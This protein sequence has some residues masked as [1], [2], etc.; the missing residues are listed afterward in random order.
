MLPDGDTLAFEVGMDLLRAG[1]PLA[2]AL[3]WAEL[4]RAGV[5]TADLYCGLASALMQ[6][7]GQL[8][9]RPFELWAGKIF[10]EGSTLIAKA[11]HA[12]AMWKWLEE[13]PEAP[14]QAP[15]L[16]N[17]VTEMI[18]FLLVH[19]RVLPDAVAALPESE[20]VM[21]VR[22]LGER[23]D[24]MYVPVL[25]A[26]LEGGMGAEAA[27]S[28][29][30]G[31]INYVGWPE[32]QAS[33]M[34]ARDTPI[35]GVLGAELAGII[36]K[37]P[38]GWDGERTRACQPYRGIGRIDVE[39]RSAGPRPDDCAALIHARLGGALRDAVAWVRYAPCT[40]KKG[41]MRVD[42]LALQTA[43]EPV[44]AELVL[45][46][47]TW[48]HESTPSEVRPPVERAAAGGRQWWKFW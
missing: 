26:A 47:F 38:R 10:N 42:A 13:L 25:R 41:A 19:E 24:P 40:I 27:R 36:K 29:V 9:R 34:A 39:L 5:K 43:L 12:S 44:G 46:G 33:I 45:H 1:Q 21:A 30:P 4:L 31:I 2:A 48:S 14:T 15:L 32:V 3:I 11:P 8:V 22:V 16:A 6:C 28:A 37:L 23:G 35:A 20:R 18:E 7:R 17:E